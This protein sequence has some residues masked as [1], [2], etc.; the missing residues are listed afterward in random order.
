MSSNELA[1]GEGRTKISLRWENVGDDLVVTIYNDAAHIGAVAVA[2]YHE[3]TGR[4]S[5]SVISRPGHKDDIPANQAAHDICKATK[6]PVCVISGIHVDNI[7]A[8]EI[9]QFVEN[10]RLVVAGF[11]E[12]LSRP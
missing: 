11:I 4:A 7:S 5:V 8:G 12:T 10:A 3:P 9:K 2:E 1:A 6:R